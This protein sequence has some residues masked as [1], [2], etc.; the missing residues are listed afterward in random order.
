[1]RDLSLQVPR[2]SIYGFIGPNGSGKTTTIRMI[3]HILL[4]DRG[5]IEVLGKEGTRAAN[6]A[7]GYL[8]EERGLYKKMTVNRLL[9][10]Y[11]SLKGMQRSRARAAIDE[12]LDRF[13]LTQWRDKKIE[14]LSKGMAQKVQFISTVIARPELLILDEPFSGLDPVNASVIREAVLELNAAGTTVIFSTHDMSAAEELCDF[15]FMIYRGDKVLDGTISEIK[16]QY[17]QDVLRVRVADGRTVLDQLEGILRVTDL[18]QHQELR[19]ADGLD[20]QTLLGELMKRTRVDRFELAQ[21][22]LRDIFLDLAGPQ[23][24][25]DSLHEEALA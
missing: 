12:W 16:A 2:G 8:P 9:R 10:Y 3:L 17:G 18:G 4:P 15:V 5:K 19:L 7:V 23:A 14:S 20:P 22:S 25:S 6:D 21:P 13:E 11:A 24:A 1:M